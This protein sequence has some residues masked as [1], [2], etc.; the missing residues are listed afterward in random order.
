MKAKE[1]VEKVREIFRSGRTRPYDWRVAQLNALKRFLI[2]KDEEICHA[3]WS[4]LRKGP[5]E[6]EVSEQGV[7]AGRSASRFGTLLI[8][9]DRNPH[10]RL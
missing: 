10:L 8:G 5:F 6:S 2:E 1:R 3:L 4:D 9:C 7:V